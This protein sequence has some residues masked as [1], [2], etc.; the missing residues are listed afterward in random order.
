MSDAAKRAAARAA[1]EEIADGMVLGLGTGSTVAPLLELLAERAFD[2]VGVPTSEATARRCRELGIRL[3]SLDEVAELDLAIDGA[4]E[5]DAHLC[6]TKGGGGA[7]L[8]EKVVACAARR[9][10]VIATVDKQVERLGVSFPLP[11]E[12]VPFA[13][14]PVQRR[15]ESWGLEV[16]PREREGRPVVTD[17]GN[18][19]LDAVIP[20]GVGDPERFDARLQAIPGL[21]ETG[22]F[23]N[24]AHETL[25][26]AADGTVLRR[27]RPD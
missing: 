22:L 9:F 23:V 20:G 26:G 13:S 6:L 18:V 7:L 1:L 17:N 5:I 14:A 8:R 16:Q 24:L 3:T 10:V 4:D 15:L 11:L 19:L 12:V 27:R 21:V 2:V 25:L